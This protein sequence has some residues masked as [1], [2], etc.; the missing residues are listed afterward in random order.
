MRLTGPGGIHHYVE[1]FLRSNSSRF[2][3]KTVVDIPAGTGRSSDVLRSLGARVEAF[4]L[5]PESFAVDGLECRKA[6]L[7]RDIPL[8]SGAADYVLSQ[9]GV[10]HIPD[11]VGMFREFNRI[12]KKGG[13]LLIT[14]PNYSNLRIK[15]GQLLSES[16]YAYKKMPPNELDSIW[17][18]GAECGDVYYGHVFPV[19]IQKLRLLARVAGFAIKKVHRTRVN[20]SSLALM[21]LFYPLILTVNYLAYL[22]AIAK[23]KEIPIEQKREVYGEVLRYGIDPRILLDG[24]LFVEFEKE[25]EVS[26][27]FSRLRDRDA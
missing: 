18:H 6:D 9:E 5:F 3:G 17:G 14:T 22:R 8:M 7:S 24:Y 20:G 16:E 12:L 26:E 19:G 21:F 15:I 2:A 10:E 13:G 23:R 1:R 25:H 11:Q 27:E 4:D